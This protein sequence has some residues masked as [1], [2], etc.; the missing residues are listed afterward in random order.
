MTELQ[1]SIAHCT[2]VGNIVKLPDFHLSNYADVRK[3]LINAGGTYKR[4]T[5]VFAF[6][7][8]P[9]ID[10]LVG[11]EVSNLKKEF[12]FFATPKKIATMIVDKANVQPTDC[13]LEPSA[14][15]GAIYEA[16]KENS[17]PLS[18]TCV[19]LME[20]NCL[21]LKQKAIPHIKANFLE[22]N[23]KLKFHKIIA[24]PPFSKNQDIDHIYKMYSHLRYGGT[25]VTIASN[26]WTFSTNRKELEFKKWLDDNIAEITYLKAG[27]FKESG[28]NI[29]A[30]IIKLTKN[31]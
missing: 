26:H 29:E 5:F 23:T 19:E 2:V 17:N 14:G 20:A 21:I 13:V 9:V 27:D 25:I 31:E 15:Q 16:I 18:I 12:Q 4:N 7:A 10:M 24:N 28:T 8:R 6:D 1:K 11:G 30:V 22:W 3:A